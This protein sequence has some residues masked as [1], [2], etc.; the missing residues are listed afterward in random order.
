MTK[1]ELAALIA[2]AADPANTEASMALIT[3]Q[4]GKLI[5]DHEA[6]KAA[7]QAA[8]DAVLQLR[9]DNVLLRMR[10]NPSAAQP[11]TDKPEEPEEPQKPLDE[12]TVDEL[13][14][15]VQRKRETNGN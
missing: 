2:S 7:K 4:V 11:E 13:L 3:E 10:G 14:D 6:L 15:Y 1:E 12:Y 9:K 8:D 5:D